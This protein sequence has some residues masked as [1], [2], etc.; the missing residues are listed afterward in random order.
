M[1]ARSQKNSASTPGEF[2]KFLAWL[3]DG[4]DSNGTKY[5]ETRNKLIH[6]FDRKNCLW[7]DDLADET[8]N[9]VARRLAEEGTISGVPPLQFCYITAKFVLLEH[10]R[11]PEKRHTPLDNDSHGGVRTDTSPVADAESC[12]RRFD[13]LERCLGELRAEQRDLIVE[14]YSGE[15]RAKIERRR[16]QA[17]R[18]GVSMNALSIRAC[19]I[20]DALEQCVKKCC[21]SA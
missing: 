18:L 15:Q 6:Y 7:P 8:M 9:R 3:D 11:R 1:S 21:G 20:R 5:L 16:A 12:A 10:Q 17:D 14:Y 4:G 19:R 13:C 2:Q